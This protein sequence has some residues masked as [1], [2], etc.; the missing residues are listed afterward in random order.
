[1]IAGSAE[2]LPFQSGFLD[3]LLFECTLSLITDPGRA[4]KEAAR[5]LKPKGLVYVAD[6]YAKEAGAGAGDSGCP[7]CSGMA[8]IEPWE[9]L[10]ARF[11]G[12]GFRTLCFE[13]R[14]SELRSYWAQLLFEGFESP[15]AS[16][17]KAGYFLAVLEKEPLTPAGLAEYR[18][19][20]L[21]KVE[22]YA[23]EKSAF[24][25]DHPEGF[26]DADTLI[27]EGERMLCVPLGDVARIRTIQTSG[28]TGAPKRIWFTGPDL[29]RTAAFF[30][31][32]MRPLVR[33]G[34]RCVI[35]MSADTPG[36]VA[37]LLRRGLERIGVCSVIH[38]VIQGAGA[39]E[40]AEG[41]DC[42]VGLPA[43]IFW[44]CR[45]AP[46]LRPKTV[47]LS[48][49]YISPAIITAIEETWRCRVFTHYGLTETGYGLAVQCCARGGQHI[50]L[51]D[52]LVEIINPATG[53][54]LPPG[55][56][57]E[58]VLTSL[59][60]GALPLI[61]YRTGDIGSLSAGPCGCG[62][63]LP[64]LGPI[65]GRRENLERPVNIHRLDDLLFS[66][67]GIRGYRAARDGGT[68]RLLVEGELPDGQ[69]LSAAL[70][71]TVR[72]SA[73]P[74][75]PYGGKRGIAAGS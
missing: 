75:M 14:T 37:D 51:D 5:V 1:M 67:P 73:G 43:E 53:E 60:C 74:V 7:G 69:K 30:A 8:R 64:R 25:R 66:L 35:M 10:A 72:V 61:G 33:E 42:L 41:G 20:S 31:A 63:P 52:Y 68:L 57:G 58:I 27:R 9:T 2:A 70:G 3:A 56:E 36:S 16:G 65:R 29:E 28:S 46:E 44:L 24:Y 22:R 62:S 55:Q 50:R 39:V 21:A 38:G 12:A 26:I 49:D 23:R 40:A 59:Y 47:L 54:K 45:T 15:D 18:R 48:A 71:V 34:E 32:G 17:F 11:S 19:E 6:L 4:L 13:D